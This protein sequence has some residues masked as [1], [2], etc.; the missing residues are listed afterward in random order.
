MKVK[1][2]YRKE[3]KIIYG[4]DSQK[5]IRLVDSIKRE[6]KKGDPNGGCV[7]VLFC[8]LVWKENEK[9][10]IRAVQM[11][12]SRDFLGIMRIEIIPNVRTGKL[13]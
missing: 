6:I 8:T 12:N 9:S 7:S 10:R 2:N 1:T 3:D 4:E 13:C 11:N 5:M